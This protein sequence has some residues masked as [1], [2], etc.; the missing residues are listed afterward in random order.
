MT[1]LKI[2]KAQDTVQ[3]NLGLFNQFPL[4]KK[5]KA[6][7]KINSGPAT[8]AA[9]RALP[10]RLGGQEARGDPR[11][12]RR[13]RRPGLSAAGAFADPLPGGAGEESAV[14]GTPDSHPWS[15]AQGCPLPLGSRPES[16]PPSC[17]RLGLILRDGAELPNSSVRLALGR[18]LGA[19]WV[20]PSLSRGGGKG[21][22]TPLPE[23]RNP[24]RK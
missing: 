16:W 18:G 1:G 8:R 13:A 19:W 20:L 12:R 21:W 5:K 24:R 4:I 22:D 7:L 10:R 17:L 23:A 6:K 2:P 15:R 9:P 14:M 11:A 3:F